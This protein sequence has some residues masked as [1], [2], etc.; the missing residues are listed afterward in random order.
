ML[1]FNVVFDND[2]HCLF[3]SSIFA[4]IFFSKYF[5]CLNYFYFLICQQTFFNFV[6][7]IFIAILFFLLFSILIACILRFFPFFLFFSPQKLTYFTMIMLGHH[8]PVTFD[9]GGS[10]TWTVH[11]KTAGRV[12]KL[13]DNNILHILMYFHSTLHGF[14]LLWLDPY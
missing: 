4:I 13:R 9:F 5:K 2:F 10:T 6:L 12:H 8:T 7:L 14:R 3:F 1:I 11:A